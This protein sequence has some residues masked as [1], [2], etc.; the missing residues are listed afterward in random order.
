MYLAFI[1]TMYV[2]MYVTRDTHV[3]IIALFYQSVTHSKFLRTCCIC[4]NNC[5]GTRRNKTQGPTDI[6][7]THICGNVD[8]ALVQNVSVHESP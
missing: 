1:H 3:T 5:T 7:M 6:Y 2:C 4:Y 8:F